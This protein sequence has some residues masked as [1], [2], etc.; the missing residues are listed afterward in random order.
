MYVA[1][2]SELVSIWYGHLDQRWQDFK[3][4]LHTQQ[5]LCVCVCVC[6]CEFSVYVIFTNI[7]TAVL[8]ANRTPLVLSY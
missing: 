5:D 4:L 1:T 7:V 8:K 6:V 3:Y 2:H